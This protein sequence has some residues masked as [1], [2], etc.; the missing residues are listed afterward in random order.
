MKTT[1]AQ[2][3]QLSQAR[4]TNLVEKAGAIQTQIKLL[5]AQLK[6]IKDAFRPLGDGEYFGKTVKLVIGSTVRETL[7][8]ALAK[9][10]LTVSEIAA[11]TKAT[12][13]TTITIR[14]L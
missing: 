8:P 4:Q 2:V 11:C 13:V 5:E 1:T 7:D 14:A 6:D 9:G 3:L 12:P 10:Y